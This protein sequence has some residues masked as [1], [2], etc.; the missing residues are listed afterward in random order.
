MTPMDLS[1]TLEKDSALA[2]S[3][4]IDAGQIFKLLR[5]R[6]TKLVKAFCNCIFDVVDWVLREGGLTE[7]DSLESKLLV[8]YVN[9]LLHEYGVDLYGQDRSHVIDDNVQPTKPC[10]TNLFYPRDYGR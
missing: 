8:L 2:L 10:T 9:G 4:T 3:E 5:L 6:Q 7:T 1:E